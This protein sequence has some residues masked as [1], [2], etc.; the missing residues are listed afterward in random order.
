MMWFNVFPLCFVSTLKFLCAFFPPKYEVTI[1]GKI[2][3]QSSTENIIILMYA[4]LMAPQVQ[5]RHRA[6]ES[7]KRL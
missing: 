4:H 6:K 5:K 2:I 7:G 1:V 3:S